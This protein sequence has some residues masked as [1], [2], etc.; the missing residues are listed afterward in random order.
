MTGCETS[1]GG[2]GDLELAEEENDG[3]M[4]TFVFLGFL[5]FLWGTAKAHLFHFMEVIT[6]ILGQGR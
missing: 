5:C 4:K 2:E 1:G 6:W 3:E